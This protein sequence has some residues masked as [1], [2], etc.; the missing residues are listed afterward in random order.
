VDGARGLAANDFDNARV[1]VAEGV[2]G[3]AAKKSR[4]FLPAESYT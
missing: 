2:D 4:Y 1:G 3:D